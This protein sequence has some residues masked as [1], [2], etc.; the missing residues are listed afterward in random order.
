MCIAGVKNI[1]EISIELSRNQST[2][3]PSP[4]VEEEVISAEPLEAQREILPGPKARRS[5]D[6][7]RPQRSNPV[8]T[9]TPPADFGRS[10]MSSI[11]Q[12]IEE[13]YTTSNHVF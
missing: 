12:S 4:K 13:S 10:K 2:E 5:L 1:Y 11:S 6:V 7:E 9:F 3:R 8:P